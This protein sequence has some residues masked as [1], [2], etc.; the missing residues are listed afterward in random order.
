MTIF[1]IVDVPQNMYR[2]EAAEIAANIVDV[3]LSNPGKAICIDLDGTDKDI[4]DFLGKLRGAITP[5]LKR[6]G[7]KPRSKL[8]KSTNQ[9]T[10]TIWTADIGSER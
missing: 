9:P 6:F 8:D 10:V 2:S 4:S 1:K 7:M 3:L 5:R